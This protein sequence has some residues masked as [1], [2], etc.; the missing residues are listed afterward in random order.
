[1][2][3]DPEG[4]IGGVV[5]A[6][7]VILSKLGVDRVRGNGHV[8]KA[9]LTGLA[10]ASDMAAVK[11]DVADLKKDFAQVKGWLSGRFGSG[12]PPT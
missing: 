11:T 6:A 1:M 9:D 5:A 2:L 12:E 3:T 8:T 4:Y 7:V 10:S